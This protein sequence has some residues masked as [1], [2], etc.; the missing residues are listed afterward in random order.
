MG[1]NSRRTV[2]SGGGGGSSNGGDSVEELE[3]S[4]TYVMERSTYE[5]EVNDYFQDLLREYNDRDVEGIRTHINEIEN[6]LEEI[7]IEKL[8]FGGSVSRYTYINGYSDVDALAIVDEKTYGN[9]TPSDALGMI[10]DRLEQRYPNSDI[11]TGNLAVTIKYSDGHEIQLLPAIKTATG[12]RIANPET[13][14]WSN[15][16]RPHNFGRQLTAV[17]QV[18]NS[19]VVPAIKLY[20]AINSKMSKEQRLSGY[21]IESLAVEAF[22]D[23]KGSYSNKETL[24][25]LSK[26]IKNNIK[27]NI[28][29]STGQ[30]RNVDEYLGSKNSKDRETRR[31][32]H[33]KKNTLMEEADRDSSVKRWKNTMEK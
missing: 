21:H 26:Y 17:N 24:L 31:V 29:D 20:K 32:A 8:Q 22:K 33:G 2:W 5:K 15:V 23:Y 25:H 7:D 6:S 16:T 19:R 11:R 30:S 18:N 12:V 1:S 27:R 4:A 3:Q 13:N 10:R 9:R 14:Q 28:K